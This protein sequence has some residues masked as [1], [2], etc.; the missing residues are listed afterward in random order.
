MVIALVLAAASCLGAPRWGGARPT[1]SGAAEVHDTADG[2]FRLHYTRAGDDAIDASD[3]DRDGVPDVLGHAE[4]GLATVWE[5]FVTDDGWPAP[6]GD[7][8]QGGD[9]RLDVYLRVLPSNGY[10]HGEPA[11]GGTTCWMELDPGVIGL[12]GATLASVAGHELHHCLQFAVATGLGS[13]IYE[14]TSTYAQYLLFADPTLALARDALW[15]LRLAASEG[16][17]DATGGQL[18]Y[19]AM[20]WVKYLLDRA[21]APRAALLALWQAMADAGGWEAGHAAALPAVFGVPTLL[22]G[23]AEL[24]VWQWFACD[25]DDGTRWADDAA[26]CEL[27]ADVRPADATPLPASG[28]AA[29]EGRFGSVYVH[30]PRDCAT[31]DLAIEV[32]ADAAAVV[33]VL[34]LGAPAR[35]DVA[36]GAPATVAVPDWNR[37][38]DVVVIATAATPAAV[39][40]TV[41][42]SGAY[43]PA[44]TPGPCDAPAADELDPG[45]GAA[46]AGCGCRGGADGG[47]AALALVTLAGALTCRGARRRRAR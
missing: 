29:I 34:G 41:A 44:A 11:A 15:R 18:E 7:D 12:G 42:A 25:R 23:A 38:G 28:A 37:A 2:R 33:Q 4:A 35:V 9:D 17:L 22:D 8:G 45:D 13:W 20:V 27:A 24:A 19:A 5:A 39:T 14:A 30:V 10:A 46:P 43:A 32:T 3:D 16:A 21:D 6:A 26:R 36:A 1:L 31:A 40:W 47:G